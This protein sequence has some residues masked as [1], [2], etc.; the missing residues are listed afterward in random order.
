MFIFSSFIKLTHTR[1]G[2]KL[3]KR[4][5]TVYFLVDSFIEGEYNYEIISTALTW[6]AAEQH[7]IG[8]G[9]LLLTIKS[10]SEWNFI[11]N[12][13]SKVS[14]TTNSYWLGLTKMENVYKDK[15]A[16]GEAEMTFSV[17]KAKAETGD[18]V[19]LQFDELH[20]HDA[21]MKRS[22]CDVRS[23]F[24]CKI[25]GRCVFVKESRFCSIKSK[26]TE[27]FLLAKYTFNCDVLLEIIRT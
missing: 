6:A 25:K 21:Y 8:M 3:T 12:M 1:I 9:G 22:P 4:N 10:H 14:G 18:C 11:M 13:L 19:M 24:V 2:L 16:D 17:W 5:V 23:S 27:Y 20:T 26:V 7:C 15:T